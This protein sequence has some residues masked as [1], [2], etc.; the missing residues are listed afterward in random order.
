MTIVKKGIAKVYTVLAE[1]ITIPSY[2]RPYKWDERLVLQLLDDLTNHQLKS[3]YRLGTIVFFRLNESSPLEVVDGQ[4]RLITLSLLLRSLDAHHT[5]PLLNQPLP[6]RISMKNAAL[7]FKIISQRLCSLNK[8]ERFSLKQ[9]LIEKCEVV[10]VELNDISE[11]FQFFDSQNARGKDLEPYDLL[12]AF[13]LREMAGASEPE[14]I[15]CVARWEKEVETGKLRHIIDN[16]L[17]RIRKWLRGQSG[18]EF[19]KSE[20][21]IF[22]GV[23]LSHVEQYHYLQPYRITDYFIKAYEEDPVRTID[24]QQAEYPFQIDQLVINGKRFFEYIHHYIKLEQ[25]LFQHTQQDISE[26]LELLNTYEGRH[27]TGD[28]YARNLFECAMLYYYD[29]FGVYELKKM[30]ELVFAWSYKMRLTQQS[31]KLATMDNTGMALGSMFA[32]TKNAILPGDVVNAIF[33]CIQPNEVKSTKTEQLQE[34]MKE[35]GYLLS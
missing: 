33:P 35:M 2:Q 11:A 25:K 9:F 24:H 34:R 32:R 5:S 19:V 4:Q 17:Y 7:N 13:H 30:S 16:Y 10:V 23:T 15:A 12:K 18:R 1:D 6:H 8:E 31:V 27:R 3:A 14:K 29:K 21:F 20:I 22:K 28:R 26:I